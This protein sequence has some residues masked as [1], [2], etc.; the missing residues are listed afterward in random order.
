MVVYRRI[1]DFGYIHFAL[2]FLVFLAISFF[3]GTYVNNYLRY[4]C[5]FG[6]LL[7]VCIIFVSGLVILVLFELHVETSR[8]CMHVR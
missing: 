7:F 3:G 6:V 2:P 8:V 5:S 4:E 1:I